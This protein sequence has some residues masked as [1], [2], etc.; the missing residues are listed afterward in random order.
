MSTILVITG[1][2]EW[3]RRAVHLAAAVAREA[4]AAVVLL[5]MVP[6]AHLEYLGAGAREELLSFAEFDA[7]N[8]YTVTAAAYGVDVAVELFEYSDLTGGILSAAEQLDAAAVFAAPPGGLLAR[9]RLWWLRRALRRPLYTLSD[10]DPVIITTT[11]TET[12]PAAVS[13]PVGVIQ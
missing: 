3:T 6:V 13:R 11:Q 1:A 10:G 4:S 5:H 2:P 9:L 8:E 7:L 12:E